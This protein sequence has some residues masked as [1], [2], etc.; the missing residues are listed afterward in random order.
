MYH[1]EL[2]FLVIFFFF[3]V[4]SSVAWLQTFRNGFHVCLF[5]PSFSIVKF[6]LLYVIPCTY[7]AVLFCPRLDFNKSGRRTRR[8]CCI[9][10]SYLQFKVNVSY[11]SLKVRWISDFNGNALIFLRRR[12][13]SGCL[14]ANQWMSILTRKS[15]VM[16]K[17]KKNAFRLWKVSWNNG[18]KMFKNNENDSFV[19]K[20]RT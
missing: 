7:D 17:R 16:Y 11:R 15:E 13:V 8:D 12:F 9:S 1:A 19:E 10:D 6:I 4:D 14:K 18:T 3:W 2:V 5:L 20:K